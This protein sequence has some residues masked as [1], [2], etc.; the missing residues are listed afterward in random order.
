MSTPINLE[1]NTSL[2][3]PKKRDKYRNKVTIKMFLN[4]KRKVNLNGVILLFSTFFCAAT[5]QL[6]PITTRENNNPVPCN[7]HGSRAAVINGG[8]TKLSVEQ[9]FMR[10]RPPNAYCVRIEAC[11]ELLTTSPSVEKYET[12]PFSVGGFNWTFILQPSGNKT[13]LGTW[14]SAYVAID[15]SGLVGENREVYADLKFL[16]YSKA[17]DQYL[18]SI[19]TEMRRFHQFRTTWGTPNFTRHF[20]FNAKDKEYI[21][22]NDQCVFG[23]DIS[24][25]PYFNKWEVLS[26]D[27]TVYGPK[28]WKLKKF[29]TLIKDFYMSDEFSIGGK[30]WALKVYPNGKGTGVLISLKSNLNVKLLK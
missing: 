28:S 18:T 24:V 20:D 17:Y 11:S 12:R 15:P 9:R 22:D 25:Y 5:I 6:N 1:C 16:V 4:A 27:K 26:I 2:A 21:F 7:T 3:T 13:N 30:K 14:I 23:V 29:S 10:P 8:D 19:D